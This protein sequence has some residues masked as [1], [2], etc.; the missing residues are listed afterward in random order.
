MRI[1]RLGGKRIVSPEEACHGVRFWPV[2]IRDHWCIRFVTTLYIY[3]QEVRIL[4]GDDP[5]S[6]LA[7]I[8][9]ADSVPTLDIDGRGNP[10][11]AVA[12]GSID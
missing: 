1:Y 5:A 4:A 11:V 9:M 12:L 7:T 2:W 3:G 10:F 6:V 8:F